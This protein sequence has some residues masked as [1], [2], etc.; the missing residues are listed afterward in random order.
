MQTIK[1]ATNYSAFTKQQIISEGKL[2]H[3]A[4]L[5]VVRSFLKLHE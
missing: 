2:A 4:V 5:N 1:I 3:E